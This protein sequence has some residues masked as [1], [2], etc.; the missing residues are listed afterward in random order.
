[1]SS[2]ANGRHTDPDKVN[3]A[4][5]VATPEATRA[6]VVQPPVTFPRITCAELDAASYNL[7]Y[8]IDGVLVARQPCI[9]AGGK[10][11]LKTSILIDLGISLAMGGAFLG[12]LKVNRA[13]RVGIMSGESGLATIQETTRRICAADGYRLADI[14]GLVFSDKLPRFG[15]VAHEGALRRW[16]MANELEVVAVDPAYLCISAGDHGDVFDM[17]AQLRGVS[18]VCQDGGAMLILCHHNKK[19]GKADPYSP[20]ELEDIA[21]AGFQEFARQWLL[22][23]RRQPYVPGT[24]EHRLWL[25]AGGSAGHSDLWAVDIAEGKRT[26]PGGRRWQVQLMF[27]SEARERAATAAEDRKAKDAE[28]KAAARLDADK[29]RIINALAKFPNGETPK[30]IRE[31]AG[32][33]GTRFNPALAALLEDGDVVPVEIIK[34]NRQKPYEGYVLKRETMAPN[35]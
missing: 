15:S 10:K 32:L 17:G 21:W 16:I 9:L 26:D 29:K 33:S 4:L 7:E 19:T 30:V 31:R 20:P 27:A 25:S 12:E 24:G 22:I 35:E 5:R 34:P 23:G 2:R 11:T 8:L 18:E 14:G 6:P 3:H 28:T 13:S 1:M